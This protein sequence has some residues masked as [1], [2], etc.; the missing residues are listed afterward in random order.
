M[1]CCV[2]HDT[3]IGRLRNYDILPNH[4]DHY[5]INSKEAI[6][7]LFDETYSLVDL[8]GDRYAVTHTKVYFLRRTRSG[9]ID[10]IQRVLSNHISEL[11]PVK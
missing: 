6:K 9:Y 1:D 11:K 3:E 2:L 5:H 10:T 8:P 4:A 7:G